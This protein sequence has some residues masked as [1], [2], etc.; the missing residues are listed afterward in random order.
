VDKYICEMYS[1][2]GGKDARRGEF[3]SLENLQYMTHESKDLRKRLC[4][5]DLVSRESVALTRMHE[6]RA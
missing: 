5:N 3:S 6:K 4:E 2:N 1:S